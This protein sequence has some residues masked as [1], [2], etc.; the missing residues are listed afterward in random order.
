MKG[1]AMFWDGHLDRMYIY[2]HVKLA[3]LHFF[4]YSGLH[5]AKG[6]NTLHHEHLLSA[7]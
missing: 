6:K 2:Q 5:A 4:F 1:A 7:V 3:L